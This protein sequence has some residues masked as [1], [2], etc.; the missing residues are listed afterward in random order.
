MSVAGA[1][2]ISFLWGAVVMVLSGF[3]WSLVLFKKM[4]TVER[5]VFGCGLT[6]VSITLALMLFSVWIKA[7]AFFLYVLFRIVIGM[8][9]GVIVVAAVCVTCCC[10]CCIFALPYVG[11]VALLPVLVFE[12]SY[13]LYYLRQYGREYDVFSPPS[14]PAEPAEPADDAPAAAW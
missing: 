6:L 10:A 7:T 13:S 12:R 4:Y 5:I 14:E 9:I 11:T 1:E 8:V 3:I 2:Y